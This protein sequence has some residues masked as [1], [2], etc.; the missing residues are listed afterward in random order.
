MARCVAGGYL[1]IAMSM[2]KGG[3][4][5]PIGGTRRGPSMS[6]PWK[7]I[8]FQSDFTQVLVARWE[9]ERKGKVK[10]EGGGSDI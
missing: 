8:K 6:K 4:G 7:S 5:E 2:R 10:K 1:G 3:C 9:C